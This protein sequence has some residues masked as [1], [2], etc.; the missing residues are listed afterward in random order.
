LAL[1]D[2]LIAH[3]STVKVTVKDRESGTA[4]AL[5]SG[6]TVKLAGVLLGGTGSQT[7]IS[8]NDVGQPGDGVATFSS[9][10]PGDYTLTLDTP[11]SG[12]LTSATTTPVH[13]A[14]STATVAT[15]LLGDNVVS[16]EQP[17]VKAVSASVTVAG[18]L[19]SD[20]ADLALTWPGGTSTAS[21]VTGTT[22]FNKLQPGETIN[23]TATNPNYTGGLAS[24]GP[25]TL[26]QTATATATLVPLPGSVEINVVGLIDGDSTQ[27]NVGSKTTATLTDGGTT[28]DTLT[29]VPAGSD[30]AVS[31]TNTNYRLVSSTITALGANENRTSAGTGAV[32]VNVVPKD[33]SLKVDIAGF[34][35]G[36]AAKRA[37]VT[38]TGSGMPATSFTA[39]NGFT[40]GFI[41]SIP[42][43]T[44]FSVT[45]TAPTGYGGTVTI[46]NQK[47]T[48]AR[49]TLTLSTVTL[50][51]NAGTADIQVKGLGGNHVD[52]SLTCAGCPATVITNVGN[53]D[54]ANFTGVPANTPVTVVLTPVEVHT[55]SLDQSTFTITTGGGSASLVVTVTQLT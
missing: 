14:T 5:V 23:I 48:H 17:I 26:G 18:L 30:L 35:A 19:N 40:T 15:N 36:D 7:A 46:P 32:T 49:E 52:V 43:D 24:V 11:P 37:T 38:V 12:Y 34:L 42:Y 8:A 39:A 3:S 50:T 4:D 21:A 44:T 28:S 51:P 25:L 33:G 29:S 53:N 45:I 27:V 41:D 31:L 2:D 47:L 20:T 10:P 1:A 9:V 22:L 13:V 16:V 54:H 55:Y 6:A